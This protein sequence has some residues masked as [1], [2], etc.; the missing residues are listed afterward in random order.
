MRA[1]NHVYIVCTSALQKSSFQLSRLPSPAL[2]GMFIC[3]CF[4]CYE[5]DFRHNGPLGAD[6]GI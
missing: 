1:K 2:I 3:A 6:N 5:C 4:S